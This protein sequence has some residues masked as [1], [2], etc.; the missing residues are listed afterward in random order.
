VTLRALINQAS[1]L[2]VI[3]PRKAYEESKLGLALARRLGQRAMLL[4]LVFNAAVSAIRVGDW[5]W[6]ASEL[7]TVADME[8]EEADRLLAVS[9]L[10]TFRA[11][12]GEPRD[13]LI[14]EARGAEVSEASLKPL[15][16][17]L[18]ALDALVDGR[19]GETRPYFD[20]SRKGLFASDDWMWSVRV[21]VWLRDAEALASLRDELKAS[22]RHGPVVDALG[23]TIGAGLAAPTGKTEGAVR[24]Y[25]EALDAW[26][27]LGLRFDVALVGIDMATVLDH[28]LMEV[29][30]AAQE[31]RVILS[32]LGAI[33]FLER[34]SAEMA[35]SGAAS[36]AATPASEPVPIGESE[37]AAG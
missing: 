12:R 30:Q 36:E 25:Q 4:T 28:S 23:L 20:E 9:A 13:E 5:G 1:P 7:A 6:A 26:G 22:G 2:D 18:L 29:Q 14:D 15:V 21:A 11:L 10:G 31:S 17:S 8:L 32:E 37:V 27:S 33:P 35:R 34:L 19:L 16:D 3:D 24:L